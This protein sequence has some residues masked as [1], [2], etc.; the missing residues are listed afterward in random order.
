[1]RSFL[2]AGLAAFAL[3]PAPSS[4][5]P[6]NDEVF[7]DPADGRF[8]TSR[9]LLERKGFL[10]V[11]IVI[12]EPAIGYGGGAALLFFHRNP[13]SAPAA[14]EPGAPRAFEPP[15]ITAGAAFGTENGTKGGGIGHLGYSEGRRWRY[16]AGAARGSINLAWYGTP[17]IGSGASSEGRDVNLDGT[18]A[19][20]DVRRR[21]GDSE[22]WAGLRYMGSSVKAKF[23][24]DGS[25]EPPRADLDAAISGLGPVVEYD[26]RDNIFTPNRGLRAYFEAIR[27]SPSLGSD[28]DFTRSRFALQGFHP[29]GDSLVV[30]LR[31]DVQAVDG[32]APFYAKPFLEL[33]GIPAMRYQGDR[34]AILE[35]EGRWNLDGRWSLVGFAGAGRAADSNGNLRDAP[36]RTTVGAGFRYLIARALG[37]RAGVDIARGPEE[38]A[39]YIIVGSAWR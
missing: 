32:D 27:F 35:V 17:G 7:R 12:T 4:A 34:V 33:R 18:L 1:L 23:A 10:P 13:D 14:R 20:A 37:L 2:L 22:W 9:W 28:Y 11:P 39:F 8:D 19:V 31:A 26:G 6:W 5:A 15:D 30:G 24:R 25:P 36:S 38:K 3:L 29:A 16:V 21:F